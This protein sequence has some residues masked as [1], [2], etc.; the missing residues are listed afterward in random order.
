MENEFPKHPAAIQ[1]W[2]TPEEQGLESS[3]YLQAIQA[4]VIRDRT[5]APEIL[6]SEIKRI[7]QQ[8]GPDPFFADSDTQKNAVFNAVMDALDKRSELLHH[9]VN[10]Q[11]QKALDN[12]IMAIDTIGKAA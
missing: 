10:A 11:K 7:D 5:F 3:Q 8:K 9:W 1:P 12:L 6:S 2:H 4:L